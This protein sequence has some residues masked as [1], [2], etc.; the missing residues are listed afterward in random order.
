[1][2]DRTSPG[3]LSYV[4]SFSPGHGHAPARA[5]QARGTRQL[6]LDGTWKFRFCP[7]PG[8]LTAGFEAADFDDAGFDD[9][10][11]PSMWQLAG[12]PGPPRYGPP[13]YTNVIYPF[14]VDPPRVP[15]RNPAGEYRR[16]FTL[17]PDWDFG[18]STVVRFDG[19]DSCFAVFVNGTAAGASQGSRLIREFDVTRFV[20]PVNN[21]LAV[22]VHQWSAG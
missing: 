11:V 22:R 9:I 18:G 20:R 2:T 14:P 10:A 13:A 7:G 12:I 16:L 17:P 21:V 6:S 1:M 19:V 3:D 15:D 4:E 5:S 8:D